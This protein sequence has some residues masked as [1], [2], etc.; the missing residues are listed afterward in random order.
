M[1]TSD[2]RVTSNF[3]KIILFKCWNGEETHTQHGD[4]KSLLHSFCAIGANI[5]EFV[6]WFLSNWLY[7][8]FKD[9]LV[10]CIDTGAAALHCW[11][12][13]S[14]VDDI[15]VAL[16]MK[17]FSSL[18]WQRKFR[19]REHKCPAPILFLTRWILYTL[20][21]CIISYLMFIGPCI[22]VI[23]EE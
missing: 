21:Y 7:L 1:H 17:K 18:C 19:H 12:M 23:V 5:S 15:L 14:I 4:L 13:I 20:S 3:V 6:S 10:R 11:V 8:L 9:E 16:L 22:I 2:I